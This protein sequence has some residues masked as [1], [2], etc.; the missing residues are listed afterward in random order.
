MEFRVEITPPA[1]ADV[2]QAFSYIR[3]FSEPAAVRWAIGIRQQIAF[4]ATLPSRLLLRG[5]R[6]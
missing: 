4:L 5:P 6:E 2:A 1:E 3:Q